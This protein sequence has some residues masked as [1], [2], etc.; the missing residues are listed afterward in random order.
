MFLWK[1]KEG[2]GAIIGDDCYVTVA[3][4]RQSDGQLFKG[5]VTLGFEVP[6][7]TLVQREETY[8]IQGEAVPFPQFY[9]YV[10][11]DSSRVVGYAFDLPAEASLRSTSYHYELITGYEDMDPDRDRQVI[12]HLFRSES[13][14]DACIR[15]LE[16]ADVVGIELG[17]IKKKVDTVWVLLIDLYQQVSYRDDPNPLI[18]SFVEPNPRILEAINGR[19]KT[20]KRG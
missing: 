12:M 10:D 9:R 5:T 1:R 16:T 18:R 3:E 17:F 19:P 6:D 7:G 14:A 15:G 20:R 13:E 11:R 2:E 8:K 4:V